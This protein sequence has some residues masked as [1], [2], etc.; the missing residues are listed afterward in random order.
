M[1]PS[2]QTFDVVLVGGGLAN[3]MLASALLTHAP[4]LRI[5]LVEA[6]T[7]LGGNHTWSFHQ[8]D[9]PAGARAYVE[10]L[11]E[12][13]WP[14]YEVRFPRFA[15]RVQLP[16]AS[17]T[18][19]RL[20]HC[21]ERAFAQSPQGQLVLGRRA[22]RVAADRALLED[23]SVLTGD[24]VVDGRGPERFQGD[25]A[26]R[27]QKFLGLEL[28]LRRAAP[29]SEPLLMDARVPQ[30]SGLRFM[31]VLPFERQRVLIEDTYFS[32][33]PDL[34]EDEIERRILRYAA[35]NGFAIDGVIRRERGVLALP[36]AVPESPVD[37]G[38]LV[39][40]YAGGWFHPTTGYSFASALQLAECVRQYEPR[41][42]FGT[43]LARL[44][45]AHARQQRY[46]CW[47]NR[48]LYEAF[49]PE[50]RVHVFERFY[51]LPLATISRFY[52]LQTSAGDRARIVCGRPPRGFSLARILSNHPSPGSPGV[53]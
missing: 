9:V 24:L 2:V 47:L 21:V 34:C 8:G 48:L 29:V 7:R 50:R 53:S 40:G 1:P 15:R 37:R 49:A 30:S 17:F 44:A 26:C 16:Y 46:C 20:H 42:I 35:D 51:G 5:A 38:P 6:G 31:Y 41:A 27:F 52:A 28:S 23:G 10:P 11:I 22:V 39:S 19:A 12:H 14:A 3:A 36:G 43:G 25:S 33:T 18:S 32:E 4:Q 45:A 13:R